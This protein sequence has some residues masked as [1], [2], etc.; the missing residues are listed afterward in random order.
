MEAAPNRQGR[1]RDERID[2]PQSGDLGGPAAHS[3]SAEHAVEEGLG[4]SRASSSTPSLLLTLLMLE[5]LVLA[6][7]GRRGPTGLLLTPEEILDLLH[8]PWLALAAGFLA[9]LWNLFYR[10]IG[11]SP[12]RA[13]VRGVMSEEENLAWTQ[14]TRGWF[15]AL[16]IQLTFFTGWLVTEVQVVSFLT[17]F[18]RPQTSSVA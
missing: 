14:T 1:R 11:T 10:A 8:Y 3:R 13:V 7:S 5:F 4:V 18:T 16:L 12:G 17:K 15:S 2:V 6:F 9:L